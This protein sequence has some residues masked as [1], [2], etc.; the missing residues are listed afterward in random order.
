MADFFTADDGITGLCL[1][2]WLV[3][4]YKSK[5][6]HG[7]GQL[8]KARPHFQEKAPLG[9][10]GG[11]AVQLLATMGLSV[12]KAELFGQLLA[13]PGHGSLTTRVPGGALMGVRLSLRAS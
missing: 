8:L 5:L 3:G 2:R 11:G 10:A 4:V 1:S 9:Q 13:Q 12:R 7:A 6:H